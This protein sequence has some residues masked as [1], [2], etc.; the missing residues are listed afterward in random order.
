MSESIPSSEPDEPDHI[1]LGEVG[2]MWQ[3]G[4]SVDAFYLQASRFIA[5]IA[6]QE[7]HENPNDR[8]A[9]DKYTFWLEQVQ[10]RTVHE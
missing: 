9:Q 2:A 1:V 5:S 4:Q 6:A 7:A 8:E 10:Q 3:P